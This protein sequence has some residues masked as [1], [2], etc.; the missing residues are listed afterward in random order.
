M[1]FLIVS[2]GVTSS[3]PLRKELQ[4]AF[5]DCSVTEITADS[6]IEDALASS[7]PDAVIV[8]YA[9]G[10]ADAGDLRQWIGYLRSRIPRAPMLALLPPGTASQVLE[11][12]PGTFTFCV[13]D[14][15][16]AVAPLLL[17]Q[18][19]DI[20]AQQRRMQQEIERLRE[21]IAETG[22][23]RDDVFRLLAETPPYT[24]F[25][26]QGNSFRYTNAAAENLTGY[27]RKELLSMNFWDLAEPS[28]R[29]LV[30][31]RGMARQK[32]E[33]VSPGY[34]FKIVRKDGQVRWVEFRAAVTE[35]DGRPA[36][37]GTAFDI[38][39]RK[40]A[41]ETVRESEGKYHLLFEKNP[42]PIMVFDVETFS[43]LDVND[44]AVTHYGYSRE[45]FLAMTI[46][47]IRPPEDVPQLMKALIASADA[48]ELHSFSR[49]LKK[50]GT[51]I[52]VDILAQPVTLAG[53]PA[54]LVLVHDITER[55]QAEEKQARFEAILEATP[56]FVAITQLHGPASYVNSAGRKMLGLGPEDEVMI[57]RHRP[58]W[59]KEIILRD[60]LPAAIEHG[61]WSGESAFAGP[62]GEEIPVSQVILAHKDASGEV[63]FIS[64]IARDLTERKQLEE[65]LRQSQKMESIGTLAGGVAHDF[66]NILT[67]ILGLT[68]LARLDLPSGDPLRP[69]LDEIKQLGERAARL[70]KQLLAFARRQVLER[71]PLNLNASVGDL[72]GLLRRVIGEDIDFEVSLAPGLGTI[73][74]DASQ[75]EQVLMNLCVNARDAMPEGGKLSIE[76]A[77][78]VFNDDFCQTHLWAK[79]GNYVEITVADTGMGI[80]RD[81]IGRIFEPF[82]TTKETGKGS[83]LGLA[84]VYGIVKQHGG[85]IQVES[86][87]GRG[88][89]FHLYFPAS[90]EYADD[91]R[92]PEGPA[93]IGGSERILVI[94]DEDPVR[95]LIV[96]VLKKN[97]YRVVTCRNGEE[98]IQALNEDR[99]GFDLVVSDVVMPK[100][101]GKQVYEY[102]QAVDP[103]LRF[104]FIS[105]YSM[106]SMSESFLIDHELALLQKPFSPQSLMSR[107]REILDERTG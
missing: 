7:E 47:D 59:A 54:R 99:E 80:A 85:F 55:K 86:E 12:M 45:E 33:P 96:A 44:A 92:A 20:T 30:H 57:S 62:H 53:R 34:E 104:L 36:V 75:L 81:V 70:T 87:P 66:N 58:A 24:V 46:R 83:G 50:D 51:L 2:K 5:E 76:T 84:M 97:G 16:P 39:D 49:H 101:G 11:N 10:S 21:K 98:A 32:G 18:C 38:T 82:F 65:Q 31:E 79:P 105:G 23:A 43:I 35:M 73:L 19:L 78:V 93:V 27:S 9:D 69:A 1:N 40:N 4:L 88:A 13:P 41:E 102:S 61:V 28:Y 15:A 17:A 26:Y 67:G 42:S 107:V 90:S 6:A 71:K 14:Q 8:Q 60:A 89:Q 37:L 3:A 29:D 52:D 100:V 94:E 63:Q 91:S 48:P 77:S 95:N 68:E 106:D 72:S 25:I 56:D 22:K 103:K 74:A 64:T